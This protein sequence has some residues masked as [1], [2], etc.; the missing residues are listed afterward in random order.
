MRNGDGCN[1][2]SQ[3]F[4]LRNVELHPSPFRIEGA[5]ARGFGHRR[6]SCRVSYAFT[7]AAAFAPARRPNVSAVPSEMPATMTG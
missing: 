7:A 6:A 2:A 1:F 5:P 4:D 3:A